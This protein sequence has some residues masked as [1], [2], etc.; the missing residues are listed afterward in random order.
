ME[1]VAPSRRAFV[2][3]TGD[4]GLVIRRQALADRGITVATLL[5]LL[6][7]VNLMGQNDDLLSFGPIFGPDAMHNL[8]E[9]LRTQGLEYVVDF[10]E[11]ELLLPDWLQIGVAHSAASTEPL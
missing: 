7:G 6:E 4:Y 2:A 3:A 10:A 1:Q 11:L 9:R 5:E 8:H